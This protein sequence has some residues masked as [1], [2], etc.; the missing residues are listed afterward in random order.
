MTRPHSCHNKPRHTHYPVRTEV[1]YHADGE[2][3]QRWERHEDTMSQECQ[4]SKHTADDPRCE[5]CWDK[6]PTPQR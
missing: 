6:N 2:V 4:Y 5:G 3:E 1:I